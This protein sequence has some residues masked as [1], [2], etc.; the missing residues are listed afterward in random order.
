[1]LIYKPR[2]S[3]FEISRNYV[4]IPTNF[5]FKNAKNQFRRIYYNKKKQC[6]CYMKNKKHV[7]LEGL[8]ILNKP[9]I[10]FK[11]MNNLMRVFG[12]Y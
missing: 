10:L 6:L 2:N 8:N 4:F 12:L 3:D 5:G 9:N 1:M 7:K 11:P